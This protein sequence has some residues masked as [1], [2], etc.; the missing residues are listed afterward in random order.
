M[1]M[2]ISGQLVAPFLNYKQHVHLKNNPSLTIVPSMQACLVNSCIQTGGA[3]RTEEIQGC[4]VVKNG[5]CSCTGLEFGSW[6][7]YQ[8][9][10]NHL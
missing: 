8:E 4:L 10:L 3:H 2:F 7:P 5:H 1:H 6:Y 9:A